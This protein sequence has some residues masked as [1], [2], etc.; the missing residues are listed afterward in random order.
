MP[1]KISNQGHFGQ[2]PVFLVGPRSLLVRLRLVRN[3][4]KFLKG[5]IMFEKKKLL[6][7]LDAK[8]TEPIAIK[9]DK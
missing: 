8:P 2:L 4:K 6:L 5:E 1:S 9:L 7:L 3:M